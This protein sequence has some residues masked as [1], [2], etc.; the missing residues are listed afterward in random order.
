MKLRLKICSSNVKEKKSG[1]P[2]GVFKDQAPRHWARRK[3]QSNVAWVGVGLSGAVPGEWG[4]VGVW[5]CASGEPTTATTVLGLPGSQ[6]RRP[7]NPC[8]C[9]GAFCH[10]CGPRKRECGALW[11]ARAWGVGPAGGTWFLVKWWPVGFRDFRQPAPT[12]SWERTPGL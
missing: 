10:T 12:H 3:V 5:L 2:D 6:A 8:L 1:F 9:L 11:V 7:R 4:G